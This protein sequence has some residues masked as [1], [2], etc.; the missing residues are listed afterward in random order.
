MQTRSSS[1]LTRDQTSNPTS[2]TNTTPKGRNRRSSK[3]TVENSNL[4]E[5]LHPVG[6]MVDNRTMAEILRAPTE[7]CA[8][9]IV[10]PPILADALNPA[11]QDSLNAAA[12]GN[13]LE[14]STQDVLMIIEKKSKVR[15]SRSKL[16]ASQV[17]ACDTNSE[18]DKLTHAVN[19]QTSAMTTAM[20]AM[21]K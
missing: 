7:G 3:Q 21:L 5:H 12:G 9:A 8:E 4:E 2:S 15:N 10:V 13:L 16:I 17:K 6:R 11:D 20:T 18:I 1:R 19:R 14:R